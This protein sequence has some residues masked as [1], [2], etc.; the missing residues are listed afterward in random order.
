[1]GF[2]FCSLSRLPYIW[3]YLYH[4]GGTC[5][6]ESN[7]AMTIQKRQVKHRLLKVY[8][9]LL[10]RGCVFAVGLGRKL[11][12]SELFATRDVS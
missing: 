1:M 4:A 11:P 7:N 9:A 2:T 8:Q 10:T 3:L 6:K 12:M 5:I